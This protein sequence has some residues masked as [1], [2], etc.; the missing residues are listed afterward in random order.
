MAHESEHVSS[1]QSLSG[2]MWTY[3]GVLHQPWPIKFTTLTKNRNNIERSQNL[4]SAT[5]VARVKNEKY[6]FRMFNTVSYSAGLCSLVPIEHIYL[7]LITLSGAC[8][9][10]IIRLESR[11]LY[12]WPRW[13]WQFMS[14]TSLSTSLRCR[15]KSWT[16][17]CSRGKTKTSLVR[18]AHSWNIVLTPRTK[19]PQLIEMC[20]S[21]TNPIGFGAVSHLGSDWK[22]CSAVLHVKCLTVVLMLAVYLQ[23]RHHNCSN[24]KT[25][26]KRWFAMKT[27]R[28]VSC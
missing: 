6:S 22:S 5:T 4:D 20:K 14:T 11:L 9:S 26:S 23:N 2:S 3:L 7:P 24:L 13:H 19:N 28:L 18:C 12:V 17:L 10:S 15:D 8:Q 27:E 16:T 1:S 21:N 25:I